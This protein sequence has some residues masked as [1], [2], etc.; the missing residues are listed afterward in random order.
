MGANEE[1]GLVMGGGGARAA[2][3]VGFLRSIARRHPNLRLPILTGVSAGAINTAFLANHQGTFPEAVEDLCAL[4]CNLTADKV[5]KSGA[6]S[7][8]KS[9]VRWS[10]RLVSGG[11]KVTPPA[12][13]MVDTQPL[14]EFL[15]HALGAPNGRL[16]GVARNLET[17]RLRAV[18]I[19]TSDYH[20]GQSVTW[21]EG[22]GASTWARGERR[23]E[24]CE[25]TV[26]HVMASC[27]LPIFFPA[28]QIGN[29]WHGDGGIRLTA[30]L[31]PALHLGASKIMAISTRFEAMKAEEQPHTPQPYPP[32]AQVLGMLMNAIFLDLLHHDALNLGRVNQLVE[33]LPPERRLGLKPIELLVLR[34]SRDLSKQ[35][36]KYEPRLP[37]PYKFLLRGL[38]S[39]EAK[40]P[41]SLSMVLF[42]PEYVKHLI[43]AGEEDA[44]RR[45]GE[46]DA[47]LAGDRMPA[48]MQTG[49]WRI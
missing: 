4:W 14:R 38:G 49:F 26:E 39:R 47:F 16:D 36:T 25:L 13:G 5:F 1:L 34:P 45:A 31:S 23:A 12:R 7:L 15:S 11:S 21:S 22:R 17:G 2:F 20:S 46:V 18:A 27:A 32:P 8:G 24:I 3:Q 9:M 43:Q 29:A 44:E 48:V 35:A 40:S 19:T 41:D 33:E 30:P 42:E 37:Q 6:T 28:V 10:A